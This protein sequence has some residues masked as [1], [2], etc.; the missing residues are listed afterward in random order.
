MRKISCRDKNRE[1][2][3]ATNETTAKITTAQ[4]S[5]GPPL[6]ARSTPSSGSGSVRG[7]FPSICRAYQ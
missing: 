3:L 1:Q 5:A 2:A 6:E 7:P 4:S